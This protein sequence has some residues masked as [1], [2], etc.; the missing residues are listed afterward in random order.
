MNPSIIIHIYF[1]TEFEV[2]F[3]IFYIMPYEKELILKL[4]DFNEL[5]MIST[6]NISY[7]DNGSCLHDQ[8]RLDE[9]NQKLWKMCLY[10]IITINV[11]MFLLFCND[12]AQT[13]KQFSESPKAKQYNS[14]SSLMSFGSANN[15]SLSDYKKNDETGIELQ[16]FTTV[17]A[18]EEPKELHFL[19]YYLKKSIFVAEFCKTVQFIILVSIFEYIFFIT[20]VNK[21]KIINTKIIFCKLLHETS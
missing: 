1:L 19:P 9:D 15:L 16:S 17:R 13:Y 11:I 20:I 6:Y 18:Q 12:L 5:N 14:N 8:H 4:F 10:Y 21:Y 2:L 3:Y 7:N